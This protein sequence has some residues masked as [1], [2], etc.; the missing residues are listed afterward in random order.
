MV[1]GFG[2]AVFSM[3]C[4]GAHGQAQQQTGQAQLVF[5]ADANQVRVD[6]SVVDKQGLPV[7][8]LTQK[9]FTLSEDGHQQTIDTFSMI[10]VPAA[11]PHLADWTRTTAPDVQGNQELGDRRIVVIAMDDAMVPLDPQM[12]ES[13]KAIARSAIDQLGPN[14]LAAVIFSVDSRHGQE[15]THDRARLRAAVERFTSAGH[16][17]AAGGPGAIDP[18]EASLYLAS[19]GLLQR[20]CEVLA[21][22]PD[23][24]KALIWVSVGVPVNPNDIRRGASTL[25]L[26][27]NEW[28]GAIE[29]AR[30]AN[31]NI[32]GVDPS[33]LDGLTFLM[34]DQ[35][36]AGRVATGP[37]GGMSDSG[38]SS[39]DAD[40]AAGRAALH[41]NFLLA[42]SESTGG[43]AFVNSNEFKSK[44]T[45]IFDETGSF[46]L[47]GYVPTNAK[48]DG[49][50]RK[51]Q[52]KV[53]R[54]GVTVHARANYYAPDPPGTKLAAVPV[55]PAM[56]ALAG[57]VPTSDVPMT[58]TA[59]PFVSL[60]AREQPVAISLGVANPRGGDVDDV[61]AVIEV[62]GADGALKQTVR[63]PA[64]VRS[65]RQGGAEHQ[66]LAQVALAPGRY[67]VR[68]AV[69]DNTANRAG[70][71]YVDL[72]VPDPAKAI[73][74]CFPGCHRQHDAAGTRDTWRRADID[75]SRRPGDEPIVFKDQSR[76]GVCAR[77]S[78]RWSGRHVLDH[79]GACCQR[80]WRVRHH[81]DG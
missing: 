29:A 56:A 16:N 6:V 50:L 23:R 19:M 46:Y 49:N 76:H 31:V 5:R 18:R 70:S 69:Q 59:V 53:N 78:R 37:A 20:T 35:R 67:Q 32:Y 17:P 25:Q 27:Y 34:Q 39:F 44:V 11:D 7:R 63:V 9:D 72:D 26:L 54:P 40:P 14:D 24:R 1:G 12:V 60:N 8:D 21:T 2:V 51:I 62:F 58:M 68:A 42:L 73:R 15:F 43:R 79:G 33:G 48:A 30:R 4:L 55:S 71:V 3:I 10:D 81:G 52:V 57:L 28:T 13:A 38:R 66:L 64:Q 75:L 80:P 77:L 74:F 61:T 41:R 45:Q 65:T 22:L 36:L 47:L